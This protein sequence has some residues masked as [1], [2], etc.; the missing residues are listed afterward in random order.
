MHTFFPSLIKRLPENSLVV[1]DADA[2]YYLSQHP[3][4][5]KVLSKHRAILT[6]NWKQLA[7]LRK[8]IDL[9]IEKIREKYTLKDNE[10]ILELDI[11][12]K[13]LEFTV[14]VKGVNDLILGRK[15]SF[16]VGTQGGLKRCGGVG[17]I[18]AGATAATCFWDF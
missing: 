10:E 5:F 15:K 8:H 6:P 3:E 2:I 4:L 17:D 16:I 1:F 9:P 13:N 11:D 12:N 18:L 14:I 7:L